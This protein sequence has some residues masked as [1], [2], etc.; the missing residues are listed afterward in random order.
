MSGAVNDKSDVSILTTTRHVLERPDMYYGTPDIVPTQTLVAVAPAEPGQKRKTTTEDNPFAFRV[1]DTFNPGAFNVIGECIDN[2]VDDTA[3][4]NTTSFK[5][6]TK[7]EGNGTIFTFHNA[8]KT[9]ISFGRKP[10]YNDRRIIE[11]IFG[12]PRAGTNFNDDQERKGVVGR[13]G[14][15]VKLTN[16]CS[17]WFRVRVYNAESGELYEQKWTDHM[18]TLHPETIK[19]CKGGTTSF[20][21]VQFQLDWSH[22]HMPNGPSAEFMDA[23]K[24]RVWYAAAIVGIRSSFNG[25]KSPVR[26]RRDIIKCFGAPVHVMTS[27]D[28]QWEVAVM[29]S[30]DEQPTP[31]ISFVSGLLTAR[32]GSH[33]YAVQSYVGAQ[34]KEV[35]TKKFKTLTTSDA[36]SRH[37]TFFVFAND[38]VNPS[39]DSQTKDFLKTVIRRNMNFLKPMIKKIAK[40]GDYLDVLQ[41]RVDV[42]RRRESKKTDG[43]K[44]AYVRVKKLEDAYYAGHRSKSKRCVLFLCEGDS[45]QAMVMSGMGALSLEERKYYGVLPLKGKP[46]NVRNATDKQID[47]ND[48]IAM[49]KEAMGLKSGEVYE[50]A[51]SLRY[52]KVVV[53]GDQDDDGVHIRALVLNIFHFM[54]PSLLKVRGFMNFFVSPLITA[55]R[56]KNM[57]EF[58]NNADFQRAWDAGELRGCAVAYYKGLG[59]STPQEAK[60]YFSRLNVLIKSFEYDGDEP[61]DVALNDK[62]VDRR[63]DIILSGEEPEMSYTYE[64]K[65]AY[66]SRFLLKELPV[67]WLASVERAIPSVIDGM[68]PV[69]QKVLYTMMRNKSFKGQVSTLG[70]FVKQLTHYG[71]GEAAME[72]TIVGMAQTVPGNNNI[73]LLEPIGQYGTVIKGGKDAAAGR[74]VKTA[75]TPYVTALFPESDMPVLRYRHEDGDQVEPQYFVPLI[76]MAL[77]NSNSGIA[78]G[79]STQFPSFHPLHL[80]DYL[81]SIL[82]GKPTPELTPWYRGFRGRITKSSNG[83]TTH[84]TYT[85]DAKSNTIQFTEFP[86]R[87]WAVRVTTALSKHGVLYKSMCTDTNVNIIIKDQNRASLETLLKRSKVPLFEDTKECCTTNMV[88]HDA[89]GHIRKYDTIQDIIAEFYRVRLATYDASRA[90]RLEN[91]RVDLAIALEKIRFIQGI[92][93]GEIRYINEPEEV[94]ERSL[95]DFKFADKCTAMPAS[96]FTVKRREILEA[97]TAKIRAAIAELESLTAEAE[98]RSDLLRIRPMFTTGAYAQ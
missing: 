9:A 63:K 2:V 32:G 72:E 54:W 13:N 18:T 38:I 56:G 8:V 84:A 71:H 70:G 19:P 5:V 68:K 59:S 95:A 4:G 96:S 22:F 7:G 77:V 35:L 26:S 16:I 37:L 6:T 87:V 92:V 27:E 53:M 94:V 31:S 98:Y 91:L 52:A 89:N 3:R 45:A 86:V 11:I 55:T 57:R 85:E 64:S 28:N 12:E 50:N 78:V 79:F 15:G 14:Y 40:N 49:I 93:S 83:W 17:L 1:V 74:Y 25:D 47:D 46:L 88:F 69:Q 43:K 29:V 20:V 80:I 66:T 21:E 58:Y 61:F 30:N 44:T 36:F 42:K 65:S 23:V 41:E 24:A 48:E 33:L 75:I 34:L 81:L 67:F 90:N 60:S 51:N 82:D 97:D 10:E 76:P 39:F 73:N 62:Q